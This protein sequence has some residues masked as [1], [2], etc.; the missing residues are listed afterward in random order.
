MLFIEKKVILER[1]G[2]FHKFS[3]IPIPKLIQ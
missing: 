2:L 3:S 1:A